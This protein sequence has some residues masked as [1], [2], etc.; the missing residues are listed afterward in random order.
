MRG[1]FECELEKPADK[2]IACMLCRQPMWVTHYWIGVVNHWW[3]ATVHERCLD[4]YDALRRKSQLSVVKGRE[5]P[6]RFLDFNHALADQE[7]LAIAK[8]FTPDS[9]L[10]TLALIGVPRRGKSRIMWAVV[11]QFFDLLELKTGADCWIQYFIFPDLVSELDRVMLNR[12]KTAK[13]AFVDDIGS[14]ES[15]G[16]ERAALQQ[17]IRTRIQKG[18][19]WS[20]LVI[21]SLT[22]DPGLQ[23]LLKGRAVIFYF[24]K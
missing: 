6:E 18:D 15:Y 2:E 11:T 3:H 1:K 20:F 9:K 16:R 7:A 8:S 12:L 23:D 4:A 17:V 13:Y 22:F 19:L 21:D 14:V 5:V 10:R 24:D